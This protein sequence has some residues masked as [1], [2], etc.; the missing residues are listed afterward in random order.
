MVSLTSLVLGTAVM[1][2]NPVTVSSF[3]QTMSKTNNASAST[4]YI[5]S[6]FAWKNRSGI[7]V[8]PIIR[9][10]TKKAL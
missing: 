2:A 10:Q 9:W 3:L 8:T 5:R 7:K 1:V 4:T 6:G